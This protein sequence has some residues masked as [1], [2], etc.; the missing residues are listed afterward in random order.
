MRN[1]LLAACLCLSPAFTACSAHDSP[2]A[3]SSQPAL[4][5]IEQAVAS[6]DRPA[7]AR[8]M[9]EGRKPAE[10]LAWAGLASGMDVADI[11]PGLGYWT[12]IMADVVGPTGSV[13]ALQPDAF[14]NDEA[15]TARW[16]EVLARSPEASR[17][18]YPFDAFEHT[19]GSLDLAL[20]NNSYHELYWES[21]QYS[22]PFT[23]PD[24][25]VAA[26]YAAMR[27]G[28][29]V[30]VIDHVADDPDP[31][32]SVDATHRIAPGVVQA[33]FERAGFVLVDASELL[34]NPADDHTGI[35]FL[36]PIAGQTDRFMFKFS[37]P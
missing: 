1:I 16:T 22:I 33:D 31:R 5:S 17:I 23:D 8:A 12:E 14:H 9:D 37:K 10:V 25:F 29:T 20:I 36:P 11:M 21:E 32:A 18:R 2:R 13:A 6:P 19:P 35:A 30:V 24:G 27:P 34:A 7:D 26:L 4:Q 28:G 15:G 3:A